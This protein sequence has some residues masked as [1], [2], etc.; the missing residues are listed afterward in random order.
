MKI[1]ILKYMIHP[2]LTTFFTM[3]LNPFLA[4]F[5]SDHLRRSAIYYTFFTFL[6][7]IFHLAVC[8]FI[9]K[10]ELTWRNR[11]II[12]I[13]VSLFYFGILLWISE[14][15][16]IETKSITIYGIAFVVATTFALS[17]QYLKEEYS[18]FDD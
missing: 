17:Y 11:L 5:E 6:P 7:L 3:L 15:G 18:T 14:K 1:Q 10:S 4:K 2:L 16:Q 13:P 9:V 8:D 12:S